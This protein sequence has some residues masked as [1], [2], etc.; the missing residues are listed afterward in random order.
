MSVTASW[1]KTIRFWTGTS[2]TAAAT[3]QMPDK[4]YAMDI[5]YPVMVVGLAN[6]QV[7]I[8][9]LSKLQQSQQPVKVDTSILKLT[10]RAV[11]V[12]ADK[13]G[14]AIGSIEGRASVV[15]M[16]EPARNFSFKC[17]RNPQ[18]QIFA[19]NAIDFHPVCGT[20]LTCGGDGTVG[21]WDKDNRQRLKEFNSCNNAVTC[22]RFSAQ[23]DMMAYAVGYDWA[24]G[25]QG[26][27]ANLPKG[28]F[29]HKVDPEKVKPKPKA[30]MGRR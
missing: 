25:H 16:N 30:A 19:V 15:F 20:F 14:Y 18:H 6:R 5:K 9:D 22:A 7:C 29:L 1:D 11:Q 13:A 2:P 17:H 3:L 21:Y 28:L 12:F 23:G 8:Y 26:H 10:T 27:T 4:I 24:K